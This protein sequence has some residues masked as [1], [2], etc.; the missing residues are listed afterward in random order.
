MERERGHV[1]AKDDQLPIGGA[2][3]IGHRLAGI[4]E[5]RIAFTAR[6]E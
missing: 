6:S 2:Q 5:H 1:R 4:G 3:E